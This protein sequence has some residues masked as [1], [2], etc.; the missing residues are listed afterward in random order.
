MGIGTL[1]SIGTLAIV[2]ETL[3]EAS[4]VKLS[5]DGLSALGAVLVRRLDGRDR[6][7]LLRCGW[8]LAQ[9]SCAVSES[10]LSVVGAELLRL[11][12]LA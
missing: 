5:L 10:A 6:L 1:C 12:S 4:L 8:T 11:E 3:A 2:H 7:V 9:F